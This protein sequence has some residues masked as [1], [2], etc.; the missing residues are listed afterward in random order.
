MR[1]KGYKLLLIENFIAI[2][3]INEDEKRLYIVTVQY[4]GKKL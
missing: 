3:K 1:E 2:Y 4:G